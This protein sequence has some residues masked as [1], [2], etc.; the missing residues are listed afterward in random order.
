MNI[1]SPEPLEVLFYDA[2]DLQVGLQ[3]GGS[4]RRRLGSVAEQT[5]ESD[6]LSMLGD[7]TMCQNVLS[8]YQLQPGL[9]KASVYNLVI[10]R[11]VNSSADATEG[12]A[13][14][15][16]PIPVSVQ[17]EHCDPVSAWHYVGLVFVGS[18]GFTS[19]LLLLCIIGEFVLG[20]RTISKLQ[21]VGKP[22]QFVEMPHID[23]LTDKSCDDP[24][25]P[26]VPLMTTILTPRSEEPETPTPV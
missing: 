1:A 2:R 16:T 3:D 17:L 10:S 24:E 7:I 14:E 9:S 5:N 21:K 11:W 22:D 12:D 20:L 6:A 13:V 18:V 19:T 26:T 23:P 8:C 15:D 4:G 25:E